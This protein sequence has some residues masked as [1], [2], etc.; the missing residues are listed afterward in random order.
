MSKT[1]R[2]PTQHISVTLDF[3]RTVPGFD[4]TQESGLRAALYAVGFQVSDSEGNPKHVTMLNNKNVRCANLPYLYRKTTIFVGD[5]RPD[6]PYAKIY[7]GVDIL[8][9]GVYSERDMEFVIDLPYDIPVTEKV[10]TRKYTKRG[11]RPESFDIT[12]NSGDEARL[13]DAFGL[14]DE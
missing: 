11:E 2:K 13:S 12:F 10:N 5:M 3:L 8:D 14:G 6:Y 9:V 1:K 7:N 4:V